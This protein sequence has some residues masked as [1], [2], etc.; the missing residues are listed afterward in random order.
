MKKTII[1]LSAIVAIFAACVASK[2]EIKTANAIQGL[3]S[4]IRLQ[5]DTTLVM[6]TD[7]FADALKIDSVQW[8]DKTWNTDTAGVLM[9]IG[10]APSPVSNLHVSYDGAA[11]DIPVFATNSLHVQLHSFAFRRC[12]C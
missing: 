5:L 2:K 12:N 6:L 4:P 7:Y 11:Y 1:I 3:A 9:L 10:A 8:N